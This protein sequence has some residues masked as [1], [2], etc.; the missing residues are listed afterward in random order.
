M[1]QQ[2]GAQ[3]GAKA[4]ETNLSAATRREPP[5]TLLDT[6][7]AR[8]GFLRT[9]R[10]GGLQT[11]HSGV[12]KRIGSSMF[13]S[14]LGCSTVGLHHHSTPMYGVD[15]VINRQNV[16]TCTTEVHRP[17][18]TNATAQRSVRVQNFN[19]LNCW[20]PHKLVRP[21]QLLQAGVYVEVAMSRAWSA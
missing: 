6:L 3:D 10:P 21:K 7:Y 11:S 8:C 16:Q 17:I 19:W 20:L 12:S 14:Y 5:A 13:V 18:T 9:S 15:A 2:L 4:F 1:L